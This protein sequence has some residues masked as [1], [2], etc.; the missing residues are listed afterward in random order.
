MIWS[1]RTLLTAALLAAALATAGCRHREAGFAL[2]S[3]VQA[4]SDAL[5]FR[6]PPEIVPLKIDYERRPV[7]LAAAGS[8]TWHG[9]VPEEHPI[10]HA[11]VQVLP[12]VWKAVRR[13]DAALAIRDG[14]TREILEVAHATGAQDSHWLD[15]EVDLARW[16]GRE[17]TLEFSASLPGLP[18]AYND[19]NLVAW[20]PV[21]LDGGETSKAAAGETT[22]NILFIVVDTLRA[23]HLTPYGYKVRDT[24]PEIQRHLAAPGTVVETAYSQAPWTLPSVVSFMTGRYPGELL[25]DNAA[26]YGIP[27]G[28]QPL[29]ERLA[30]QG[31]DTG[32]FFANPT[33]HEGAGFQRGFRTY[34]TPPADIEWIRRHADDLNR[35]AVP[36]LR[37][38]QRRPFFLY[39]HY[40]DPHDPYENPDMVAG[41]AQFMPTYTGPVAA[42]WIHGIYAGKLLLTHPDVDIP[43]IKALYD[44]EIHYVD[45]YLG[46]LLDQIDPAVLK[47]TLIVLTADHGEELYDHGGWKHGQTLYDEQIHVPLIFRWDGHIPAGKRLAGTV[48]L[49]DLVPTLMA[50]AGAKAD[51]AWQGF[52]LLPALTGKEPAPRRPSF[53]EGL[54]GGPLRAAAVLDRRKLILFNRAE[55]FQPHDELQGFLW[56]KDLARFQRDELYDLG[57]DPGE[58]ENLLAPHPPAPSPIPSPRPGEGEKNSTSSAG[59][60]RAAA[61]LSR[62]LR[63][64]GR[65]DGGEGPSLDLLQPLVHRQLSRELEGLWV[66]PDGLPEGSRLSGS[67]AFER[68]PG[69]W[70]PYF[71]G[72]GDHA[73]L[74]GSRIRFDLTGERLTKGLRIQGDFGR[75]LAVEA[76]LDG[77]PLPP[78]AVQIGQEAP[79]GRRSATPLLRLWIAKP[80]AEKRMT[81]DP[82]TEKRLT[83]LGYIGG[84]KRTP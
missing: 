24:S 77:K 32:G 15:M 25:A 31:Y 18:P 56:Q 63:G 35:H 5:S 67:I 65:G 54:S 57:R 46:A 68:P 13:L 23:D 41:R 26:T 75:I 19:A 38:H 81:V 55:P 11:G 83:N 73:E 61:P 20:G 43:Y 48:R 58:R 37:A 47:N 50:A 2:L 29:A 72:A 40:V 7:V 30:A 49:L 62:G 36:W 66:I 22:P 10:L 9:E 59:E 51:P 14:D 16:A 69:V 1:E 80:S 3:A 44:G 21:A 27:D 34:F 74:S 52:N 45:R 39:L 6:R 12:A 79:W 84:R 28:V 33:L 60:G 76:S 82:E 17:V 78:A 71:L 64:D 8:W 42:D 70:T 53:S 4:K